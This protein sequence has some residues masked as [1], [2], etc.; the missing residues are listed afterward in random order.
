MGLYTSDFEGRNDCNYYIGEK[1]LLTNRHRID[2]TSSVRIW[3]NVVIAG[4]DTQIWTHGFDLE[5]KMIIKPI[6]IDD[7]IYRL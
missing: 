3:D 2:C 1:S 7:N 6:V 5:R 4:S